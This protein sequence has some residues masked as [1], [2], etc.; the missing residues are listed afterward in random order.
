MSVN[1]FGFG[2][3]NSHVVLDD[4]LHYLQ[5]RGITGHHHT[6]RMPCAP[7]QVSVSISEHREME[8]EA[9]PRTGRTHCSER[10]PRLLVWSAADAGA[11]QRTLEAY[12]QYHRDHVAYDEEKLSQLAYTLAAR[13]TIMPWRSFAVVHNDCV[14]NGHGKHRAVPHPLLD[15]TKPVRVSTEDISIGFV[16]TG[17]GAQYAGMG[18]GLQQYPVFARSLQKSDEFLAGLGCKWLVQGTF[19]R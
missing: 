11:L 5:R 10:K 4:A 17:Q 9:L 1:S 3:T 6:V 7:E 16:F 13:R 15:M 8:I 19:D 2:G 12:Q 18:S 14:E